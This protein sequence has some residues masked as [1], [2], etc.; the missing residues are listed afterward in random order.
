MDDDWKDQVTFKL[1]RYAK[2][3]IPTRRWYLFDRDGNNIGSGRTIQEID[4][5]NRKLT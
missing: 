5:E 3:H 1:G 2:F 4:N